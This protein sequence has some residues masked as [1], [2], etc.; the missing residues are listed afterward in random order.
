MRKLIKNKKAVSEVVSYALSLGIMAIL[1]GGIYVTV[2]AAIDNKLSTSGGVVAENIAD[3]VADGVLNAIYIKEN[4]PDSDYKVDLKIPLKIS[5]KD[6]YVKLTK[7][8]VFVNTTD[9]TVSEYASFFNVSKRTCVDISSEKIYG[10]Q[11]YLTIYSKQSDY[12]YKFDFGGLNDVSPWKKFDGYIRITNKTDTDLPSG[13]GVPV[14]GSSFH[15][16]TPIKIVNPTDQAIQYYP[17][18]IQLDPANFNIFT[19]SENGS[20]IRFYHEN[21]DELNFWVER[22]NPWNTSTTRIWVNVS[23]IPEDGCNIYMYHGGD[24]SDPSN[25]DGESTFDFFEDFDNL[26]DWITDDGS[27]VPYIE[28]NKLVLDAAISPGVYGDCIAK[29]K[30][31]KLDNGILEAKVRCTGDQRDCSLFARQNG[32][33][34]YIFHSGLFTYTGVTTEIWDKFNCS[35]SVYD[36]DR[37]DP[38]G[39]D[40]VPKMYAYNNPAVDTDWNR[41]VL[42]MNQNDLVGGRYD[43]DDFRLNAYVTFN[44]SEDDFLKNHSDGGDFGIINQ[45]GNKSYVDWFFVKPYFGDGSDGSDTSDPDSSYTDRYPHAVVDGTISEY[46][47]LDTVTNLKTKSASDSIKDDLSRDCIYSTSNT[48]YKFLIS[49]LIDD[50][51]YSI[52]YTVGDFFDNNPNIDMKI[53]ANGIIKKDFSLSDKNFTTGW[54]TA[55]AEDLN[56]DGS[57]EIEISFEKNGGG[58]EYWS[59]CSL[60]VEEGERII[61]AR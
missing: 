34:R 31:M 54:F 22:W 7:D 43:Y 61:E 51:E 24:N 52:V 48:E 4:H 47:K 59:I 9:G 37:D 3:H 12:V 30:N 2:N 21:K 20:E 50:K 10:S 29:V 14:I 35:I 46:F 11:Q 13:G 60:T 15:N 41:L 18:L 16:C 23:P 27:K 56:S 38:T 49:D 19:A 39:H 36:V 25:S 40:Q 17:V 42:I 58:S 5:G 55:E 44:D 8:K 6:Y 33:Y 1:I 26:D 53:K 57:G 32:N 45:M 28:D